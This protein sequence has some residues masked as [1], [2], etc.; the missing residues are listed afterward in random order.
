MLEKTILLTVDRNCSEIETNASTLVNCHQ[1]GL[2]LGLSWYFKAPRIS[3]CR[4]NLP[5]SAL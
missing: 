2:W 1:V 4:N 5:R 3:G